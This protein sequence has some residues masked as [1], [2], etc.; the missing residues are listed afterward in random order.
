M[1][2]TSLFTQLQ[3]ARYVEGDNMRDHL[4]SLV[5]IR[6]RLAEMNSQISDESFV[7][8][9]RTSL[10]LAPTYRSLVTMLTAAAHESGKKLTS[11]NLIWHLN[12]EANSTA[13]EE[14]INKSNAAMVAAM[15]KAKGKKGKPSKK[16]EKHCTNCD[17]KG[18]VKEQCWDVGGGK[19]GQGPPGWGKKK[20]K[21]GESANV[22]QKEKKQ[23]DHNDE[24]ESEDCAM[25]AFTLPDDPTALIC[26]SDFRHEAH[27]ISQ[28]N[29]II[30]DCG[31]SKHFSPERSKFINY[32][33]TKP[34]PVRAADGN[35][36]NVVGKGDLQIT[37]PNGDRKPTKVTLKN[38]SYS[39]RLA[40][41]LI[42]VGILDRGG[43]SLLIKDQKCIINNPNSKQVAVIPL[44]RGLYRVSQIPKTMESDSIN[45][46]S[47]FVT[48]NELH[49][50]M[51]HVNHEDLTRMVKQGM[52]TGVELD[53]NTKPEFCEDCVKGKATRKP[54]PKESTTKY[55]AYGDKVV[56]DTWGPAQVESLG[57]KKYYQIYK[58]IWSREEKVYF[59]RKKSEAYDTYRKY[60]M[61]AKIQRNA[62]IRIFGSDRG[63]EF[64]SKQFDE[65]LE[66]AGTIRHLT[67]HDSPS[68]NGISERSNRTHVECARTMIIASGLPRSLW[69]EAISHSVWI[70]ARVPTRGLDIPITPYERAT[71]TK[72]DL[73]QIQEWGTSAWVKR[74]NVGKLDSR[75]EKGHFVGIDT[76]SK[77]Y[78]IYWPSKR[79][80]TIERD[81]YFNK[82]EAQKPDE[83]Q[84]EG[85]WDLSFNSNTRKTL[86]KTSIEPQNPSEPVT[87]PDKIPTTS[88]ETPQP[89]IPNSTI[90]NPPTPQR[91]RRNSLQGLPQFDGA[92]YGRG[93]RRKVP[94]D[95]TSVADIIGTSLAVTYDG[96]IEPGGVEIDVVDSEWPDFIT[97]Y[98]LVAYS[99]DEPTIREALNG[100]EESEWRDAIEAELSQV[101]KLHTWDLVEAPRDANIIP[102]GYAFRRKR[103][104]E[105][106]IV[107][108]KARVIGKGYSQKFGVDY[109]DTFAPTA[110]PSSLRMV[111][112]I[113]ANKGSSI[114]QFDVKNAYLNAN[115]K[116]DEIIY[117][118]LPP[119]YLEFRKLP[120]KLRKLPLNEIV[121]KLRRPIYGTKQGAH[122]WY[123]EVVRVFTSLGYTVSMADEAV[124]Y[125]FDDDTYVVV[126][127][128]T[129]DFTVIADSDESVSTLKMQIC[130]YWEISDLGGISWLLGVK[131]IRDYTAKTIS[132]SQEAYIEQI[133]AR[134]NIDEDNPSET[135]MEP[136]VDL[137]PNSKS[138]SS[139]QLTQSQSSLYREMIGSLMYL[140]VMTRPD[141]TFPISILSR[142]L[143][144]ASITHLKAASRVFRYLSG[145][146]GLVL[147]LGG[148][149]PLVHG[150]SD[151]DWAS[152]PD[153]HSM[154]GF[155][156]FLGMGAVS[157]SSKRQPIITLSSTESEY[158][159][160]THASKDIIWIHK[161][162]TEL[163]PILPFSVPTLLKC[164]NQGA[165]RLSKDSTFHG[166][167]K[168]IE[169]HYH[170][171]RQTIKRGHIKLE[172]CRTDNMVADIFTKALACNKLRK[173]RDLLGLN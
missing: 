95:Q 149:K 125:K 133:L 62:T 119:R 2:E 166:R 168:H 89:T 145:T 34:E 146:R 27:S 82:D 111:L 102:S 64:T 142:Y 100:H 91:A 130:H 32:E 22:S 47:K 155:V 44:V 122:N 41:T 70:R 163:S 65:H 115:L 67:V 30:I 58:D 68:S 139:V 7:A 13:L 14:N 26:T 98:G 84:I 1:Y 48:I 19:E 87:T 159:A 8:Y 96:G 151:A 129:D 131:I 108:Y 94:T 46:A 43:Y 15:A 141:I 23:T 5:E 61:W 128:A 107:R 66:N 150:Y 86:D 113:G 124:F 63:G 38:V 99:E 158:V 117:M 172:Y 17:R 45:I 116:D 121:C 90:N 56:A 106:Y 24:D 76:E 72:P 25:L 127:V 50:K 52:V 31:A 28:N 164:D 16:E 53:P 161:L 11:T 57:G 162:L 20:S 170:F 154:S 49:R 138:V 97:Q 92:E 33:E 147:K 81:V 167:T 75:V 140:A 69:A 73:S 80:V 148:E 3:N 110:R 169:V 79:K 118:A 152:Q 40:F 135:P 6:E 103:N 54:F 137:S 83:V 93:K 37:L 156:Y 132:L 120:P 55:N 143:E 88:N 85:E 42:S 36:F 134:F 112:S 4:T 165:I 59:T 101:E 51:G 35:S 29:G 126:A 104:A 144:S 18:H 173:F 12:E 74:L 21:K 39:P 160:L 10:S 109:T 9:I 123:L 78:R 77:G 105:G 71:K 114:H 136:G 153:R 157:W 60:E 171:V